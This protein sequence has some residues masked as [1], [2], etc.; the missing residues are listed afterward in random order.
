MGERKLDI[1]QQTR[2]QIRVEYENQTKGLRFSKDFQS[3]QEAVMRDP[4]AAV[5]ER[6]MAWIKR[7]S[8]GE[9]ALFA[10]R[11]DGSPALQVDCARD[12]GIDKRRVSGAV[13]YL[14]R[15]GYVVDDEG[16]LLYPVI[17]PVLASPP[18]KDEK[19]AEYRTFV[20][21]WKVSHSSDFEEL[22]VALSTVKRIRKVLLSEYKKSRLSGQ[23]VAAS[24]LEIN[25]EER[26]PAA[27]VSKVRAAAADVPPP[28]LI[29]EVKPE[30]L[31]SNGDVDLV[32]RELNTDR[33]GAAAIVAGWRKKLP[34]ITVP[35]IVEL[36]RRKVGKNGGTLRN[37]TGLLIKCPPEAHELQALRKEQRSQQEALARERRTT[38]EQILEVWG[39]YDEQ[40]RADLLKKYPELLE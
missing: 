27:A 36:A 17:S 12:L 9:Y 13:D 19:S 2:E 14:K 21:G 11:D 28:P 1:P 25:R 31:E 20:E 34:P 40:E 4:L 38:V 15:R 33:E 16:R 29:P 24:L 39:A 8:W 7:R 18:P 5:G 32:A 22:E 6:V 35:E 26:E 23:K 10:I 3:H 37:P 30:V